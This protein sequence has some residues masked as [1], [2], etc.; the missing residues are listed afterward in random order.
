MLKLITETTQT[1]KLVEYLEANLHQ[2]VLLFKL[3]LDFVS[4]VCVV[5]GFFVSVRSVI[6]AFPRSR[7]FPLAQLRLEFASWLALALEF[8]LG[9]DVVATTVAPSFEALGKLGI[10]AVI[11]TFLNYFLTKELDAKRSQDKVS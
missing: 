10:I 9:A 3:L 2:W 1:I 4:V 7:S 8:Q 11:R 5:Y 6:I